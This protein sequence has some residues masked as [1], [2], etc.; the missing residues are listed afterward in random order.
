MVNP[1]GALDSRSRTRP[2]HCDRYYTGCVFLPARAASD[3]RGRSGFN[4]PFNCGDESRLQ[5]V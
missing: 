1:G 5:S 4:R 2:M 3:W